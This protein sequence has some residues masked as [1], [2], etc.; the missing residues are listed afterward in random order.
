[1]SYDDVTDQVIGA[2]DRLERYE[3]DARSLIDRIRSTKEARELPELWAEALA[4][5][6]EALDVA[7]EGIEVARRA[8]DPH[9]ILKKWIIILEQFLVKV[10]LE[11][12]VAKVIILR[13]QEERQQPQG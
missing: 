1:M 11:I 8:R 12:G 13:L 6:A 7:R 9:E 4:L 2:S 10:V 3:A 5:E